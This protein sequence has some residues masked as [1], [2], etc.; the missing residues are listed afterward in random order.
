M[1]AS[2]TGQNCP[3]APVQP[4]PFA[5]ALVVGGGIAGL[6]AARAL[7]EFFAEVVVL[8]RD[9]ENPRR[10]YRPG[11]PQARHLHGITARGVHSIEQLV[12]GFVEGAQRSGASVVEFGT[13]ASFLFA[14]GW[15]PSEPVGIP[16]LLAGR[17][18]VDNAI[19]RLVR[20]TPNIEIRTG[21]AVESLTGDADRITGVAVRG[22]GGPST[23][24]A[25]FVV[26]A[27]GRQSKLQD[28]L[29]ERGVPE[30]RLTVVDAGLRYATRLYRNPT[31]RWPDWHLLT[32][33]VQRPDVRRGCFV[34]RI[35]DNQ[36]IVTLQGIGAD[37]P[38]HD[39]AG[40]HD[41]AA[42]LRCGLAKVIDTME[43]VSPV[44][45]YAATANR[46]FDF[47]RQRQPEGLIALGDAV[48]A[49]N[50]IYGQGM[51]VAAMDAL[52]L[53]DTLQS[54]ARKGSLDGLSRDYQH[55]LARLTRWPWIMSTTADWGWA[56][57]KDAP[58][59]SRIAQWYVGRWHKLVPT[60]PW[61][62]RHFARSMNMVT[63][64]TALLHPRLVL[65]VLKDLLIP[66]P[67]R[68][69]T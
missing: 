57:E 51:S 45:Q 37:R 14:D 49:F 58:W 15:S 3:K 65:G 53:R 41:F 61:M 63:G 19:H 67:R 69:N 7:A 42:A 60:D 28:W 52:L 29:S 43:P 4:R 54:Y 36:V 12:P 47:H 10:A 59:A 31:D 9:S 20:E 11:V 18:L 27:T 56:K 25:D 16:L 13:S 38:P 50:P 33:Y 26:V 17:T 35:E 46:R 55:R 32:E 64:P 68:R 8:E 21:S 6:L 44:F 2:I 30:A 66:G 34:A 40:F 23:I 62:F 48:C 24:E 39:E 1:S 5:R 22:E